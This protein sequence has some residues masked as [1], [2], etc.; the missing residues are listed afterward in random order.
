MASNGKGNAAGAGAVYGLGFIGA[1]VYYIS[2]AT[3]FSDL[4]NEGTLS[5]GFQGKRSRINFNTTWGTERDYISRQVGGN[6]SIDLPGRNTTVGLAYTH[7][8]DQVCDRDNGMAMPL[9]RRALTHAD[10]CNKSGGFFGKVVVTFQ[11]GRVC[12][13]RIEQT[14]KLDELSANLSSA[15]ASVSNSSWTS[16]TRTASTKGWAW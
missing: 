15:S 5:L 7:S 3:S 9:E 2:T 14:K 6:A 12:D 1:I 4:R 16:A 8:F 10:P 13:I 11:N